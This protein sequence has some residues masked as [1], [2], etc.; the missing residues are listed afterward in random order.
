MRSSKDSSAGSSARGKT[1][2]ASRTGRAQPARRISELY[3][4]QSLINDAVA[5]ATDFTAL[6]EQVCRIGVEEGGIACVL[7]RL[8]DPATDML[9]PVA[10]N[11]PHT[12][13]IGRHDLPAHAGNGASAVAFQTA[14]KVVVDDVRASAVTNHAAADLAAQF[15]IGSAAAFPLL[16][17]GK[18][19]GTFAMF[20]V[21]KGFFDD[22]LTSLLEQ[23]AAVLGF[24]YEKLQAESSRAEVE[25]RNRE[26]VA[27]SPMAI[28]II[29]DG[30]IVMINQAGLNQAGYASLEEMGSQELS[31]LIHPDQL[32]VAQGLIQ[33]LLTGKIASYTREYLNRHRD[34]HYYPVEVTARPFTFDGRPAVLAYVQDLTAQRSAEQAVRQSEER[35]RLA[36]NASQSGVWDWDLVTGKAFLSDEYCRMFGYAP[37]ELEGTLDTLLQLVHPDDREKTRALLPKQWES[38]VAATDYEQRFVCKDGTVKWVQVRATILRDAQGK[39]ERMVGT[40]IDLTERKERERRIRQLS[41]LNAALG[42]INAAVARVTDFGK[43]AHE[44]CNIV[45]EEVGFVSAIIRKFDAAAEELTLVATGGATEGFLGG[46][47]SIRVTESRGISIRA[48]QQRQPIIVHDVAT[49]PVTAHAAANG[50]RL[51]VKTGASFPLMM[52]EVAFGTMTVWGRDADYIGP[53]HLDL[54]KQMVDAVA[55]AHSKLTADAAVMARTRDMELAQQAG[56]IGSVIIDLAAGK[57]TTS[58]VGFEVLG[59]APADWYPLPTFEAMLAPERRAQEMAVMRANIASGKASRQDYEIIRPADGARRWL[60]VITDSEFDQTGKAVR[61]IGTLQDVTEEHVANQ[62]IEYAKRLYNALSKTSEAVVRATNFATLAAIA[63]RIAV[64]D[65]G[66]RTAVIRQ[67]NADTRTLDRLAYFGATNGRVGIERLSVDEPAGLSVDAFRLGHLVLVDGHNPPISPLSADAKA[68]GITAG[69]GY[70]LSY[71]GR[72]FGIFTVFAADGQTFDD[73]TV[74]LLQKITDAIS[75]GHDKL[76]T[77]ASLKSSRRDVELSQEV[78]RIGSVITD[79]KAGKWT[80]SAVGFAVLGLPPA[81]WY[82]L[83]TFEAMMAPESRARAMTI[84]RA[85]VASGKSGRQ[86]YEVIRPADGARR[87]LRVVT[88]SE[89]DQAGKA[90]RRIGTIQDVTEEHLARQK[91]ERT[92]RLYAALSKTNEAIGRGSHFESVAQHVCKIAVEEGGMA[93]A[94]VRLHDKA[95][96]VLR[97]IAHAGLNFGSIGGESLP[98]EPHDGLAVDAFHHGH[99]VQAS[100]L[101]QVPSP[102][103]REAAAAGLTAAVSYPLHDAGDQSIGTFTVFASHVQAFDSETASLLQEI[104]TALSFAWTKYQA[105]AALATSRRDLE[106]AQIAGRI[107]SVIH[108]VKAGTW[109]CSEVGYQILGVSGSEPRPLSTFMQ[110]LKP[111]SRKRAAK[112]NRDRKDAAERSDEVYEIEHQ[113]DKKSRWIRLIL[114]GE[115]D[116]NGEVFRRIGTV[117]DVTREYLNARRATHLSRLYAALS[118]TNAAIVRERDFAAV[119]NAVCR[120]IVE[121]GGLVAAAIRVPDFG[122]KAL[123]EIA[124]WGPRRGVLGLTEIAFD[125]PGLVAIAFREKKPGIVRHVEADPRTAHLAKEAINTGSAAAA[126]FPIMV[127]GEVAG[128]LSLWAIDGSW[129]DEELSALLSEIAEAL[130]FA[131]AK[132][133]ADAR[134]AASERDLQMA[135]RAGRVGSI[136]YDIPSGLWTVSD[137]ASDILGLPSTGPH[138]VNL[139]AR[140]LPAAERKQTAALIR[141]AAH[142]GVPRKLEYNIERLSDGRACRVRTSMFTDTGQDGT[143]PRRIGTIQDITEE[144]QAAT[145]IANLSRLYAALSKTNAA[146]VRSESYEALSAEVCRIVVEEGQ[147]ISAVIRLYDPEAQTLVEVAAHGPRTGA[148]GRHSVPVDDPRGLA[149]LAFRHGRRVV[150]T[151]VDEHPSTRHAHH[152]SH[153][154]GIVAGAAFPLRVGGEPIGTMTVFAGHPEAFDDQMADLIGEIADSLAFAR[155]KLD[156]DARMVAS[157]RD[158]LLAQRMGRVGSMQ[159]DLRTDSWTVSEVGAEIL[160]LATTGPHDIAQWK[161]LFQTDAN[162]TAYATMRANIASGAA[163]NSLYAF[164]RLNDGQARWLMAR[165]STEC[166][167]DGTPLRRVGTIQDVTDDVIARERIERLSR[168]YSALSKTNEAV[169]RSESYE[170]LS[171]EVC[172]IVVE[173]GRL[174]S[175]VIRLYHPET[176][177]LVEVAAHGPRTGSL[178][179]QSMPVNDPHGLAVLAFRHGRRVVVTN[180]DEHPHTRPALQDLQAS[181]ILAVAAF[182]LRVGGEPIGT[183]TVF[184]G[185]PDAFDDQTADLLEEIADSLAFARA[186]LASEQA[187]READ[188][189]MGAII[190][191]AMDAIVTCDETLRMLVFNDAA[192]RMF[193][194]SEADAIG[195]SLNRLIPERFHADHPRWMASF[196]NQPVTSRAMGRLAQVSALRSDGSEFPVEASISH[197]EV[198]GKRLYTVIMRDVTAKLANQRALAETERRYRSL[199]ETSLNGVMLLRHDVV[200]Y[201]N[202][203]IAH[204]LGFKDAVELTGLSVYTLTAPE[205]VE[206]VRRA[207]TRL[208]QQAGGTQQP[209]LLRLQR[210]DGRLIE[211]QATAN[212]IKVEDELMIQLELRDVTIERRALAELKVFAETLEAKVEERTNQLSQANHELAAANRDLESFSYS[213]AHDLRAPLRSMIGFSKLMEMDLEEGAL[214][215]IPSHAKRVSDG[216]ARMN[217]LID[218]LL[219]VARVT[220]GALTE[221]SVD[222]NQLVREV[223]ALLSPPDTVQLEVGD[224]PTIQCDVASMRQVW[225]NLLSNAI[226]YS[227]K[228]P[229]PRVEVGLTRTDTECWFYVRDNGAG[230]DPAYADRLF[231]VFQRLHSQEQFEGTGVGLA[232]VRRIV[233]RHGGRVWAESQPNQG[234]T[235]YFALPAARLVEG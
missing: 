226:K 26:M 143:T 199:V 130:S 73:E 181:G 89:F 120:T 88:D 157:Q 35:L 206:A 53:Q 122:K 129:L 118:E 37:H 121:R 145:R 134:L 232:I 3:R 187:Q 168:L 23:T 131:R 151:N 9:L 171:A 212:S 6:C 110:M 31:S 7:V 47:G 196:G 69:A 148:L 62:R 182:P 201:A 34:G 170:A 39:A 116:Q 95:A 64:E 207:I 80:T 223:L 180:V 1:P 44:A 106:L 233:E 67:Y 60:R 18:P 41:R 208:M 25:R 83:A 142:S 172:R 111:D 40:T 29:Q 167:A 209:R 49:D 211:A 125:G 38:G 153:A 169:V 51:G 162:D 43:L 137:V 71:N 11:G 57:W 81:D 161:A 174:I 213:V 191:S 100:D 220:H 54:L 87:W 156:A 141:E 229:D 124:R 14:Q 183:V 115:R 78:G 203:A 155:A 231:G 5:R 221:T 10:F 58:R 127:R 146:V 225:T 149:V 2:G 56:N 50:Q 97:R 63:C 126:A 76:L 91:I 192:Q 22:T 99:P 4:A 101:N 85:N 108:D 36:M 107:G 84:M 16:S 72:V 188:A 74:S 68:L 228:R 160:G 33:D 227:A 176:Q 217:E 112:L 224:L 94:A 79:L 166:A 136:S 103:G 113:Q 128:V 214:D 13:L 158:L 189:R 230:F 8:Y 96:H 186:K 205:H 92:S 59:L 75:F 177:A 104:A 98:M 150:V 45:V 61:R 222:S 86:D 133:D 193:R 117:Q 52:G 159:H 55:F 216:A 21:G 218:G 42:K 30:R 123:V 200:V 132:L 32:S 27:L 48:F 197:T 173:D 178:S 102:L 119:S 77:D 198:G 163:T 219:A 179:R 24:A 147:L 190:D 66:M 70:P 90:V 109:T 82:P 114:A 19:V 234:A 65:G 202:P 184:A 175:A 164:R 235:F 28:R 165:V 139:F 210:L 152:D 154:S 195:Q 135:Q 144:H 46:I 20:A 204:I 138:E 93:T 215:Q 185:H 105:D 15:D 194:M 140:L 17:H 12:G